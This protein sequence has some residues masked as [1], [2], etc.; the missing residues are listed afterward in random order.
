MVGF[1]WTLKYGIH[2]QKE[3]NITKVVND[4]YN[5]QMK[6]YDYRRKLFIVG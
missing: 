5:W 1:F 4:V 2:H 3:Q 6:R